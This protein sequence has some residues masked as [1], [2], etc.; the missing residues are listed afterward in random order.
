[1]LKNPSSPSQ[2]GDKEVGDVLLPVLPYLSPSIPIYHY[3]LLSLTFWAF[4]L[5]FGQVPLLR[6]G[7]FQGRLG[8][9][10]L[11]ETSV[12]FNNNYRWNSVSIIPGSQDSTLK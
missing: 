2:G 4:G 11:V 5:L 3:L 10:S 12:L 6:Q 1:M 9:G 8:D 7:S